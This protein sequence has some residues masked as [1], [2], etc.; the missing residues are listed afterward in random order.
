M[1]LG[2]LSVSY[3][4]DCKSHSEWIHPFYSSLSERIKG[5][6]LDVTHFVVLNDDDKEE[7]I[8]NIK[9]VASSYSFDSLQQVFVDPEVEYVADPDIHHARGISQGIRKMYTEYSSLTEKLDYIVIEE[10]DTVHNKNY[11]KLISDFYTVSKRFECFFGI[12]GT[13]KYRMNY[14][15]YGHEEDYIGVYDQPPRIAPLFLGF[16][17]NMKDDA[18][19]LFEYFE[20]SF[21]KLVSEKSDFIS[22][23]MKKKTSTFPF[24]VDE[25]CGCDLF[26]EMI[27]K[28]NFFHLEDDRPLSHISGI[29][30][31]YKRILRKANADDLDSEEVDFTREELEKKFSYVKE[32]FDLKYPKSSI[33]SK[34]KFKQDFSDLN[35]KR[36][37]Y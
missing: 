26:Y 11:R 35:P 12:I 4:N 32:N 22:K 14:D 27:S 7:A 13:G 29:T 30:M 16:N 23:E 33:F 2:A 37:R 15:F 36:F 1:N 34:K 17:S 8:D 9:N 25:L 3:L 21:I 6:D 20:S 24:F 28:F 5:S 18:L 19:D 10:F 31:N